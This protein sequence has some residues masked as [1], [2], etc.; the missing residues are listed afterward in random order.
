MEDMDRIERGTKWGCC[1]T[2]R[3]A[4]AVIAMAL[5]FTLYFVDRP[6]IK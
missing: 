2:R 4:N 5:S 6:L 1:P 3:V